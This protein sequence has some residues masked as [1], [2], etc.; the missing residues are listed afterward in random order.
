MELPGQRLAEAVNTAKATT[1]SPTTGRRKEEEH[2]IGPDN[3]SVDTLKG[4]EGFSVDILYPFWH[5]WGECKENQIFLEKIPN[6]RGTSVDGRTI[7]TFH[8]CQYLGRFL[9]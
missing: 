6:K 1:D 4:E 9:I 7:E 3:I 5:I 2:A 8:C